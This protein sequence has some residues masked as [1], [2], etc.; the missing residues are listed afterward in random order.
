MPTILLIAGWRFYF[1]ANEGDEP[2]HIHAKKAEMEC[3]FWLK[4]DLFEIEIAL[5]YNMKNADIRDVKQI[6]YQH[7]DYI[8]LEWKKFFKQ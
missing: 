5:S 4:E 2:I 3:K 6:I 8:I 7:F 1:Y